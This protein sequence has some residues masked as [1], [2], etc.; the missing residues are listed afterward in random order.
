MKLS[1]GYV[2]WA[3]T[4]P[5]TFV[6]HFRVIK[7]FGK[8]FVCEGEIDRL[9]TEESKEAQELVSDLRLPRD[10]ERDGNGEKEIS[11]GKLASIDT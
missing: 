8:S 10:M 2:G 7:L 9:D 11:V 5:R 6:K 1:L 4:A 3:V